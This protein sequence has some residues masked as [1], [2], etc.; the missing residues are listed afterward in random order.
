MTIEDV[1]HDWPT[2][3]DKYGA[4]RTLAEKTIG[5]LGRKSL[6]RSPSKISLSRSPSVQNINRPFTASSA[7]SKSPP[8]TSTISFSSKR[9][10]GDLSISSGVSTGLAD[11]E[12]DAFKLVYRPTAVLSIE[13]ERAL[14]QPEAIHLLYVQA[15][16]HVIQ[17][18]Y[19]CTVESAILLGGLQLQLALGDQKADHIQHFTEALDRYVPSHLISQRKS[20]EWVG[21]LMAAHQLNRSKDPVNLKRQYLD[22]VQKFPFYG[23]T[24]YKAKYIPAIT[25]FYK[26]DYQGT[27]SLGLNHMGI[28][29]IDPKL[30]KFETWNFHDLIFWDSVHATF[31]FEVATN[32]KQEPTR[33]YTFKTQQAELINDL[34]HDW[35]VEWQRQVITKNNPQNGASPVDGRMKKERR[36]TRTSSVSK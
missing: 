25:S 32:V 27:V 3:V 6:G 23:S 12:T 26:Q 5:T 2:I 34:T 30:M 17:S 20:E 28:H 4:K 9:S 8:L 7:Q 14:I 19:P 1:Y 21:D 36:N 15:V 16:H 24:F 18:N 10:K 29:I 31:V 35:A 13:A 22:I 33:R 11:A